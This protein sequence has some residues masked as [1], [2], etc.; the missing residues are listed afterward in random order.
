MHKWSR[1]TR[2][3]VR[4]VRAGRLASLSRGDVRRVVLAGR[5]VKVPDGGVVVRQGG[6]VDG[7]YVL[8]SGE[9]AVKRGG[10]EIARLS[11]GDLIGEIALVKT[12]MHTASVVALGE[13]EALH[14][15]T[16][17]AQGLRRTISGFRA[18]VEATALERLARDEAGK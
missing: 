5:V 1:N 14:L 9:V 15:S 11:A 6:P 8:L 16:P 18:A 12:V 4:M 2:R 17:V 10:Q 7:A 13:V 3:V